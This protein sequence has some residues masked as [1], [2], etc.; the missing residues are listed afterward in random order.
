MGGKFGEMSTLMNY[1]FQS[2]NFR[3]RKSIRPFY[4]LIANIAAEAFG[5]IELV[6]ATIGPGADYEDLYGDWA[7]L[8]EVG[9]TGCVLLR[10]DN[11]VGFRSPGL[12]GDP[13]EALGAALRQ[14]LARD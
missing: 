10:P 4:D 9:D 6:A 7:R 3:D 13:R 14:I 12:P 11:Y 8:R 5:H 2:F 1:T